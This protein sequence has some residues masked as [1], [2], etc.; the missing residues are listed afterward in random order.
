MAEF[1]SV[2]AKVRHIIEEVWKPDADY[3]FYNW[4]QANV[5]LHDL[6]RPVI[7]YILPASGGLTPDWHQT[8]DRPEAQIAFLVRT[9]YDFKS[10]ENDALMQAMKELAA[11]FMQAV[12]RSGLFQ[13]IPDKEEV[14]Y[15]AVYDM[16]DENVTGIIITLSLKEVDGIKHCPQ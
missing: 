7:L 6:K 16:L 15:E 10:R 13:R 11:G 8:T 4:A 5:E 3:Q 14:P 2:E 9:D 1:N 12:N